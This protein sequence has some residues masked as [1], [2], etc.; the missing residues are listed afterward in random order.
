MR[1]S[2]T[3]WH[4]PKIRLPYSAD[5]VHF[6]TTL[7]VRCRSSF[8]LSTV[9]PIPAAAIKSISRKRMTTITA[10]GM[11]LPGCLKIRLPKAITALNAQNTSPL[12]YPPRGLRRH[13]PVWSVWR[14]MSWETLSD[15]AFPRSRWT[16]GPALRCFI[17][18]CTRGAVRRSAF[19]GKTSRRPGSAQKT[20]LPRTVSTSASPAHSASASIGARC[21]TYRLWHR[22]FRISCW[23]KSWS[24]M[25]K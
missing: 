6:S 7:T 21:P 8:P 11:S 23:R 22:S 10:S 18:R 13:G 9:V 20:L 12:A 17:A 19:R 25:R 4:P 14:P 2:I 3:P 1:T 5:G 24:W 16:D 15:W